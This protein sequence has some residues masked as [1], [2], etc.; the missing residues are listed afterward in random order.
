MIKYRSNRLQMCQNIRRI[1]HT[2]PQHNIRG[3]R[4]NYALQQY[5]YIALNI[6][7]PC[8]GVF[9]GQPNFFDPFLHN[10]LNSFQNI[11][12]MVTAQLT[13]SLHCLTI[14]TSTKTASINR[15]NLYQMI[16]AYFRQI[17]RRQIIKRLELD[18]ITFH[19][20]I[21]YFNYPIDICDSHN[22]YF[23]QILNVLLTLRHTSCYHYLL[24]SLFAALHPVYK[25]ILRRVLYCA[26]IYQH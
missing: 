19:S 26:R 3:E 12:N 16:L 22:T 25:C 8:P 4:L 23:V 5:G 10:I 6:S 1:S 15:N 14:S 18:H 13:P 24:S 21:Y 11:L 7:T 9:T 20:F 2:N 17:E